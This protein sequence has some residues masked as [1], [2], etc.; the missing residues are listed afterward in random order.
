MN[1]PFELRGLRDQNIAGEFLRAWAFVGKGYGCYSTFEVRADLEKA[2]A[3]PRE[4]GFLW[5]REFRPE[6][7]KPDGWFGYCDADAIK[8]ISWFK[9]ESGIEM[10]WHWDGDG[11]LAFFVPGIGVLRNS[12]CKHCDGWTIDRPEEK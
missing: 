11:T 6:D 9:H 10:G 8:A 2:D 12:D 7:D 1:L 4:F 5:G 3:T